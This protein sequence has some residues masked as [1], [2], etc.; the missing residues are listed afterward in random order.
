MKPDP[1]ATALDILSSLEKGSFTLDTL[2]DDI[3]GSARLRE[4][5]DRALVTTLVYGVLR[6]RNTID[7]IIAHFS[8]TPP[9]RMDTDIL[10]ILRLGVFQLRFLDRI[11]A[12]AAVNA[13][14]E[15]AKKRSHPR[16]SGFVNG[17]LRSIARM[18]GQPDLSDMA[19]D[20]VKG[21]SVAKSFPCWILRRWIERF[22]LENTGRMCDV[23]NSIPPITVRVNTLKTVP[24]TLADSLIPEVGRIERSG[25]LE[26]AFSFFSPSVPVHELTA[27]RRGWF[28]VQDEAAQMI[29]RLTDPRPGE[30]VLD[31]CAGLGGKTGHMA[32]LME[33]TGEIVAVD[34]DGRKLEKL[35]F[36]MERLGVINTRTLKSDLLSST[37]LKNE[38]LFD[39]VLADCPCSG[40]G[41]I[42]RNP[43][44]KWR[45]SAQNLR[46]FAMDQLSIL[47][48][49]AGMV[50]R[51]GALVY[52][53]CSIEPE[54]CEEVVRAFLNNHREFDI[55]GNKALIPAEVSGFID[56][57][58]FF[59]TLPFEHK[60]DGFFAARL[61]RT[62]G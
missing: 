34:R 58:G 41:V 50:R 2:V 25:R 27:F 16:F 12:F 60:L 6:R 46:R 30:R 8:R 22:G 1:R 3:L 23:M 42:R 4:K 54:E 29:C 28:H 44:T 26:N 31:A 9:D 43:D 20:P 57:N 53:V 55:E 17:V 56:K 61:K 15:L 59:K 33:N 7:W 62:D 10:N 13:S 52:S 37:V 38:G 36:E 14:V 32:Q 39:R 49:L 51:G 48:N 47:D 45:L 19:G 5:R 18:P 21:M 24:D 35:R 11:P 40:S